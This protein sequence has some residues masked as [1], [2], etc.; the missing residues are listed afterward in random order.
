MYL[1]IGKYGILWSVWARV[2]NNHERTTN[3]CVR[4]SPVRLAGMVRV[5]PTTHDGTVPLKDDGTVQL[6]GAAGARLFDIHTI[7]HTIIL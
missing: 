3:A 6:I 5:W 7:Y 1:R 4:P 2:F